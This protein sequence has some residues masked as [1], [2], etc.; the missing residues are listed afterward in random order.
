MKP[1][2]S[3][4]GVPKRRTRELTL[5]LIRVP[6]PKPTVARVVRTAVKAWKH[7]LRPP[8]AICP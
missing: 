4:V 6:T 7:D 3:G 1:P 5:A 2:D 8:A